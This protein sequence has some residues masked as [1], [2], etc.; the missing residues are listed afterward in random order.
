MRLDRQWRQAKKESE[1]YVK[2]I[3]SAQTQP[4]TNEG[5]FESK[6]PMLAKDPNAM[7]DKEVPQGRVS[8]NDHP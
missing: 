1:Y 8:N 2:M 5:R 7:D 4:R 6:P 3:G